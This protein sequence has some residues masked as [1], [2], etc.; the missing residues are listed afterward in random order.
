MKDIIQ[1]CSSKNPSYLQDVDKLFIC[2]IASTRTSRIPGITGAGATS[3]LTDYTPAADVELIIHG[4][5]RCLPEIPQ[6]IVEGEAAPTPAV[7]TKASLELANI[8]FLVADAGAAVKP[9]LPYIKINDDPGENIQFGKAVPNAKE[10]YHQGLI[11]GSTLSKLT[12]HLIIGESTPAGTTTALGLLKALGYDADFKVSGSMP[13]NPHNLK[14]SIVEQG[15]KAA[16]NSKIELDDPFD[17]VKA[18][19]DPMIPAVAGIALGSKVP[20]TLAGGTQMTAVCALIKEI[21][22]EFLENI[23][24]AT[25][26]YVAED[27]TSDIVHINKQ[28]GNIPIYVIDPRFEDSKNEGLKNYLQGSVKEGVGAGG[29]MFAALLKGVPITTIR[30]RTEELVELLF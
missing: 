11:L 9:N 7:I 26:I 20:V 16:F 15:L 22:P 17:A 13:E 3:E 2:V 24:I 10:I 19:G 1:Y 8:P 21:S 25:T 4:E 23:S 30:Q 5:P 27:E 6:T 14:K 28:I 29:A 18:V 12:N